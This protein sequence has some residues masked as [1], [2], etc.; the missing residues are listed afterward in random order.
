ML[1]DYIKVYLQDLQIFVNLKAVRL[2]KN[3]SPLVR[4]R[5]NLPTKLKLL[6]CLQ[7]SVPADSEKN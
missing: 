4:L 3:L 1:R 5:I 7:R 2:K 6:F